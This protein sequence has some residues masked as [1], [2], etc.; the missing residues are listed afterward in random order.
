MRFSSHSKNQEFYQARFKLRE[1]DF[2][3]I[4]PGPVEGSHSI[5]IN[6]NLTARRKELLA[7]VRK[8]KKEKSYHR[9]WTMDGKIFL[10]IAE[11]TKTIQIP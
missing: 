4:L 5:F 3:S 8:L 6:E 10:R 11:G 2:F 7:K 9:V 1:A